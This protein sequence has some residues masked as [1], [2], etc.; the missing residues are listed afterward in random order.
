MRFFVRGKEEI[1]TKI[2]KELSSWISF[3]VNYELHS[4]SGYEGISDFCINV[5][6]GIGADI[7]IARFVS[8]VNQVSKLI[9]LQFDLI[10]NYYV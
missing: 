4:V 1:V 10:F 5:D 2:V 8:V 6:D 7:D 3:P 9:K